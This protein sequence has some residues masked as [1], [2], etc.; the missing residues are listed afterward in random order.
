VAAIVVPEAAGWKI[1]KTR[2]NSGRR[3]ADF[4]A[5]TEYCHRIP[6]DEPLGWLSVPGF[7]TFALVPAAIGGFLRVVGSMS[8]VESRMLASM[9]VNSNLIAAIQIYRYRKRFAILAAASEW[10]AVS[11]TRSISIVSVLVLSLA[12]KCRFSALRIAGPVIFSR[13]NDRQPSG[14][15]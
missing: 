10:R 1:S 14:G 3:Q 13:P 5:N 6:I 9:S 7:R 4:S 12:A 8:S 2:E 15:R 11:P